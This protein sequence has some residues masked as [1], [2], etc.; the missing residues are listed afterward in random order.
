MK[1]IKRCV[2]AFLVFFL[3]SCSEK[4]EKNI[5]KSL[6]EKNIGVELSIPK[7]LKMYRPF[8]NYNVDS[9]SASNLKIYSLVDASCATCVDN[10]IKWNNI[11]DYNEYH[12]SVVLICTS[13]D[14]FEL[15]KHLCETQQIKTFPFPFFFDYKNDF[16]K[17]NPFMK[18]H[19]HMETILTDRNNKIILFGNPIYSKKIKELYI[20]EVKKR[21]KK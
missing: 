10:I 7:K 18:E 16:L 6:I 15:I 13:T 1:T 12:V 8:S 3:F 14:N 2:F 9:L 20:K 4:S 19:K 21:M 17:Q 5:L 11:I